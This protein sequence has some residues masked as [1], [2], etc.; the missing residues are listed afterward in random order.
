MPIQLLFCY[1]DHKINQNFQFIDQIE[2]SKQ[3]VLMS[4]KKISARVFKEV[5]INLGESLINSED[6]KFKNLKIENGVLMK[7]L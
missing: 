3:E 2:T 4:M 7:K 6:Q 1:Q 5:P